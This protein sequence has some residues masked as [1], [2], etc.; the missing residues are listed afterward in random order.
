METRIIAFVN[1][2]L[3]A[4]KNHTHYNVQMINIAHALRPNYNSILIT[5]GAQKKP[6]WIQL[7]PGIFLLKLKSLK[8]PFLTQMYRPAGELI[9]GLNNALELIVPDVIVAAEDMSLASIQSA[10]FYRKHKVPLIIYYGPAYHFGF[11]HGIP[12]VIF[13]RSFGNMI[14][15]TASLFV[16]KTTGAFTFLK[17]LGVPSNQITVIPPGID[18]NQFN[19]KEESVS[20][21]GLNPTN[22]DIV[23][24]CGRLSPEKKPHIALDAFTYVAPHFP[25]LHLVIIT[26][27]GS[28]FDIIKKMIHFRNLDSRVTI[29]EGIP[30]KD[31]PMIYSMARFSISSSRWEVFGMATLES[32]A[33]GIP[34]LATPTS[35]SK[36]IIVPGKNGLLSRGFSAES[37]AQGIVEILS[38]PISNRDNRHSVRQTIRG[39]YDIETLRKMWSRVIESVLN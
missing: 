26:Q 4:V 37:L 20:D 12:H 9:L 6:Q 23:V 14:N 17:G 35:G 18:V 5:G 1:P 33:C 29:L 3:S 38:S 30:N 7:F 21:Y 39:S 25:N 27:G 36:Q 24:F 2:M 16:A 34:V 22:T 10:R 13:S 32:I 11:P 19:I 15:D 8:L 28:L 31:M